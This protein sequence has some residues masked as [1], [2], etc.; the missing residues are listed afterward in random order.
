MNT[1]TQKHRKHGP[2]VK[3]IEL[4]S[5]APRAMYNIRGVGHIV[6]KDSTPESSL[7]VLVVSVPSMYIHAHTHEYVIFVMS[8]SW[9]R[10]LFVNAL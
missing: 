2:P 5:S 8:S 1:H 10:L 7:F 4:Q 6:S 3:E 9:E